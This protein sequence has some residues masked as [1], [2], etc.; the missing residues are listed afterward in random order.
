MRSS[1]IA[2]RVFDIG[3]AL[4]EI[5][6]AVQYGRPC[7]RTMTFADEMIQPHRRAGR[8]ADRSGVFAQ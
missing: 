6:H 2:A 3:L 8:T 7:G 1:T 4:G 5:E